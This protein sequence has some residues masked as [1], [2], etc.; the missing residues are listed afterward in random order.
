PLQVV[1]LDARILLLGEP[2]DVDRLRLHEVAGLARHVPVRI[3]GH[4]ERGLFRAVVDERR[5]RRRARGE[6]VGRP[7]GG[8]AARARARGRGRAGGGGRRSGD[9]SGAQALE[10]Q[11]A[12]SFT[13]TRLITCSTAIRCQAVCSKRRAAWGSSAR[14]WYACSGETLSPWL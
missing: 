9:R 8:G 5:P 4:L 6:G 11:A 1:V 10:L 3:G 13:V 14:A 12:A 2:F 7:G